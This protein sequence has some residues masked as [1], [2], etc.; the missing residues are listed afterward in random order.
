MSETIAYPV[1]FFPS[2]VIEELPPIYQA[3]SGSFQGV[4]ETWER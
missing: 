3:K 1:T 4:E 2:D